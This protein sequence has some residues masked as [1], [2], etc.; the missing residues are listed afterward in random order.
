MKLWHGR[1][2]GTVIS[3]GA[4]TEPA[5]ALMVNVPQVMG[6]T[7]TQLALPCFPYTGTASGVV[8]VPPPKSPVWVEFEGGNAKKPIWVG[9]FYPTPAGPSLARRLITATEATVLQTTT[10]YAITVADAPGASGGGIVLRSPLGATITLD[11]RG[12]TL[13][14]GQGGEIS[15]IGGI[16]SINKPNLVVTK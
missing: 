6:P 2:R 8:H 3:P 7:G 14:D 4:T 16:V 12:I 1:Y 15:M 5:G 11:E 10:G 9:G 13:S